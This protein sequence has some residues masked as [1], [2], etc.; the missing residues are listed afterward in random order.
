[1]NSNQQLA[2][3]WHL[4]WKDPPQ[5]KRKPAKN[6]VE[7]LD[8]KAWTTKYPTERIGSEWENEADLRSGK[9]VCVSRMF[10]SGDTQV[11][12][13]FTNISLKYETCYF[14]KTD[15]IRRLESLYI[16][17]FMIVSADCQH[18]LIQAETEQRELGLIHRHTHILFNIAQLF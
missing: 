8:G 14:F 5:K 2:L 11:T 16:T 3:Q 18:Q 15:W 13:S 6:L 12:S 1:M 9:A 10:H 7:I 4:Y 17:H